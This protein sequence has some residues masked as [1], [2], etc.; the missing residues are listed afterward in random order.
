[1]R[2]KKLPKKSFNIPLRSVH[3]ILSRLVAIVR[4]FNP[5]LIRS[6]YLISFKKSSPNI[7]SCGDCL[8]LSHKKKLWTG[9]G[10]VP[11]LIIIP[12]TKNRWFLFVLFYF[13]LCKC[14]SLS[15]RSLFHFIYMYICSFCPTWAL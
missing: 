8:Q 11:I 4:K 15:I 5:N 6:I 9:C 3:R 10:M 7:V 13:I 12:A 2:Y 14:I 1:M